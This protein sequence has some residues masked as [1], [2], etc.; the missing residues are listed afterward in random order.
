MISTV[1]VSP[2]ATSTRKG[3]VSARSSRPRT[4]CMPG[5]TLIEKLVARRRCPARPP[6][7]ST[8]TFRRTAARSFGRRIVSCVRSSLISILSTGRTGHLDEDGHGHADDGSGGKCRLITAAKPGL[9][10]P[11]GPGLTARRP[12]RLHPPLSIKRPGLQDG[13][14][15]HRGPEHRR[16]NPEYATVK[17]TSQSDI[18]DR[19]Q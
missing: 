4:S 9:L 2:S 7:T 19:Q 3:A 17:R 5:R 6:S 8:R 11:S 10:L 13:R 16:Y 15:G 14:N 12:D 18:D 1:T